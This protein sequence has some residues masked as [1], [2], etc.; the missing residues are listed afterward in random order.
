MMIYILIGCLLVVSFGVI[1]LFAFIA[2][3]RK[4]LS[5]D[6]DFVHKM[7]PG[8]D[9]S[10][11]GE[12]NCV[13]FAKKVAGGQK[14][15]EGCKLIK[16][17]NCEKIK[18]YF[19]PT[20][21]KSSK[22][23]AMVKCKGGCLAEDKYIYEGAKNCAVQEKL[24]SGSKAC[25]FACLGCGNC[26]EACRYGAIKVN[27]RGVAEVNR[28]LC[29]GC[30]ECVNACPNLVISMRKLDV[31]VGVVCNNQASD[32]AINKKCKVG[33]THCGNCIKAC[34]AGAISVVDNMPV[35][36]PSKC[37]E[38]YKCVAVCPNHVISRL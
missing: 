22:L 11:C 9:C 10:M 36:D 1:T 21:E 2:K 8:I 26:E 6:A 12:E 13:E 4:G 28:S 33:C 23:V 3:K 5:V 34:P 32:P 15:P 31:S 24:H 17:E 19:K 38:C 29:T 25:K 7:L 16:P 18:K 20:Y 30:G 37:I 35:I 14:E 27:E